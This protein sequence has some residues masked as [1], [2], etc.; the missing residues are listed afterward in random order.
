MDS[1]T[2][3][4]AQQLINIRSITPK[5][6]GCQDILINRLKRCGFQIKQIPAK[7][8]HNFWAY[9][10]RGH[11]LFVFCGH[12]DV[13]PPGDEQHWTSPPFTATV[14]NGHLYGR[15]AADMKGA[16][17][18]MITATERFLREH[19]NYLGSIGFIITSDEEGIATDGTLAV[20]K[21]LQSQHIKID[22]CLVGEA[23]SCNQI[24]DAIK[25]GRRGSLHGQLEVFGQ[26][27]HI[28][29]PQQI[30]NPIHRSFKALHTLV[31]KQWDLGNHYFGPTSFQIY[32]INADAGANNVVPGLLKVKFNFR[33]APIS[34]PQQLK[35][36]VHQTFD[37]YQLNYHLNWHLASQPF[38]S[39]AGTLTQA[40][41][42]SIK[43]ICKLNPSV[44][45]A[46]GTSDGRFIAPMGTEVVELGPNGHSIHQ[47]DEHIS[48]KELDTLSLLYENIL[49]RL[50]NKI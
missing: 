6:S 32:S 29:Y 4:L 28:A 20:V 27:G 11:P 39:K 9:H 19:P 25:I 34:T 47:V 17:A 1:D 5:D 36:K 14:R 31:Q 48:I 2:L 8:V 26:Q 38:L 12:T 49:N 35:Q 10:G 23:T 22:W 15:G 43:E 42:A 33:F 13:V 45:T 41:K 50:F 21:Y 37:D 24:G 30:D 40:I 16:L 18:A 3:Q 46:G 44:N 7:K